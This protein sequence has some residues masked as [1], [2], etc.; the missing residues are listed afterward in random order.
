MINTA[1]GKA[2]GG[3]SPSLLPPSRVRRAGTFLSLMGL[4]AGVLYLMGWWYQFQGFAFHRFAPFLLG[5]FTVHHFLPGRWR[6]GFFT[7]LSLA[8]IPLIF[9][10]VQGSWLLALGLL[11]IGICHLPITFRWRVLLLL[12][13]GAVFASQRIGSL[14]QAW[15]PA[16]W[17]IFGS[18]FSIRLLIYLYDLKHA[19]Q[20]FKALDSL[21]YFFMIPNVVF[22]LFP[23]V[24]YQTW[25]RS[26]AKEKDRDLTALSGLQWMA[27]GV[28]Q[29]VLYRLVYQHLPIDTTQVLDLGSLLRY[30]IWPFMLYLNVSGQFHF[31]IGVVRLFGYALPETHHLFYLASS[32]TDFWRRINIYWKD[33][34]MKVF[35]YPSYFKL[36]RFGNTWALVLGT[37]WV[38]VATWFFHAWLWFWIRGEF[39]LAT[40]DIMFWVVLCALV[41]VNV[42]LESRQTPAQRLAAQ[43]GGLVFNLGL[44]ARTTGVFLTICVLWSMWVTE[45][46]TEWLSLFAVGTRLLPGNGLLVALLLGGIL[47]HFLT[48]LAYAGHKPRPLRFVPEALRIGAMLLAL[49]IIGH[50]RVYRA[51]PEPISSVINQVKSPVMNQ[52]DK[53]RRQ[54]DYYEKLNDVGWDNPDLNQIFKQKPADWKSIRFTRLSVPTEG[55]PYLLLN[56]GAVERH[57]GVMVSINHLGLRDKAAE[58]VPEPNTSR[59]LLLG[60]SHAYGSGVEQEKDFESILEDSL[61]STGHGPVELLNCAVERYSPL[62]ILMRFR[63]VDSRL[64][65]SCVIWVGHVVDGK[66]STESLAKE[67]SLA[68]PLPDPWLEDLVER[69]GLKPGDEE[70]GSVRRLK[71]FEPELLAWIFSNMRE[72]C[73]RNGMAMRYVFLPLLRDLETTL[74]HDDIL[75]IAAE[76]NVVTW[77][78]KDVYSG[79]VAEDLFVAP[80]DVHPSARGHA[81]VAADL[82]SRFIADSTLTR[83]D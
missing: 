42:V 34:M 10:L 77:D 7:L 79:Y 35:Y 76:Q 33:F 45:S 62:D 24:D 6:H 55:L 32:F 8:S 53:N 52:R 14:G 67:I 31:V 71:P 60:A 43:K 39:L 9:G 49:L 61:N 47:L 57:R 44:A 23:A 59:I 37:V 28:F 2:A 29:L 16:I 38:F 50:P 17:P 4:L 63:N 19:R 40:H 15:S 69:A 1:G 68:H 65:G 36:R 81:L 22:P 72:E 11:V 27:R 12:V 82:Y 70:F 58:M 75:R 30:L 25:T 3:T 13:L 48:A 21:S 74:R 83:R 78:L 56:P 73:E 20:P 41:A 66:S 26:Q 46:L 18:L 54:R 5:G 51:L 64:G 80:W